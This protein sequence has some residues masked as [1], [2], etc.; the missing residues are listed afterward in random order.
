[1]G[2]LGWKS[3][4]ASSFNYMRL[5][6]GFKIEVNQKINKQLV[7]QGLGELYRPYDEIWSCLIKTARNT[8]EMNAQNYSECVLKNPVGRWLGKTSKR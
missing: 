3:K 8:T 2:H 7:M 5:T 6:L 4:I 1:M